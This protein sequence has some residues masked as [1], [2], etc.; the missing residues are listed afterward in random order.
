MVVDN[1]AA[2]D[3]T[4]KVAMPAM[5]MRFRPKRSPRAAPVKRKHAKDRI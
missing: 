5:N 2:A 4:V 1:A 3:P